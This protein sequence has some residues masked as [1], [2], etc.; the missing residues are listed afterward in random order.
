MLI[1]CEN[2]FSMQNQKEKHLVFKGRIVF[3]VGD[4]QAMLI[5]V[6]LQLKFLVK[7]VHFNVFSLIQSTFKNRFLYQKSM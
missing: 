7:C 6:L 4:M 3:E 2:Y 1:K 5:T